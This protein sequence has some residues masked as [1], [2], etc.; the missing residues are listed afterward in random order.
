[1]IQ[2]P[3][4]PDRIPRLDGIRRGDG[5]SA[6]KATRTI[7]VINR[8]TQ[9]SRPIRQIPPVPRAKAR[10]A[11]RLRFQVMGA[12]HIECVDDNGGTQLVA[13]QWLLRRTPFDSDVPEPPPLRDGV[14]YEYVDGANRV[15]IIEGDPD[16]DP[17]IPDE[18]ETQ[19][20]TQKFFPGDEIWAERQDNLGVIV[21]DPDGVDP[22]QTVTL[23]MQSDGRAFAKVAE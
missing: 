17:P 12:D 13:K 19:A 20:I 2:Q 1:M 8:L 3:R 21:V 4:K 23:L 14:K 15:G 22:P 18:R 16:A 6:A 7:D 5:V 10:K 11:I 9:G